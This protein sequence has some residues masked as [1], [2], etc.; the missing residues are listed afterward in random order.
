MLKSHFL[1]LTL[2]L[3]RALFSSAA[4]A[5]Q[6]TT[7]PDS[8]V[9]QL[10]TVVITPDRSPTSIRTSTVAVSSLPSSWI[11]ALPFRSMGDALAIVPGIA[12]VEAASI[13]G[14]PRIIA[15]GFYGGGETDYLSTQIDGVPIASLGSGVVDWDML[16]PDAFSRIELV[17]GAT[18]S[19]HGDAAV[20]GTLNA[21]IPV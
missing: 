17:R 7:R 5:Q 13:G 4:P 18:S 12:V 21:L 14:N 6:P 20:G 10:D 15:R 8:T 19:M 3:P 2:A 9:R 1:F 16:P 11:R